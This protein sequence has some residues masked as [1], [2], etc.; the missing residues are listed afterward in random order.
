MNSFDCSVL[1][2]QLILSIKTGCRASQ[3]MTDFFLD[4]DEGG[5]NMGIKCSDTDIAVILLGNLHSSEGFPLNV[6]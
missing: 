5:H 4:V 2:E 1:N 6:I 3:L